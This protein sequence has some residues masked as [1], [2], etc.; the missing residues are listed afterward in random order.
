METQ[1]YGHNFKAV[2]A[3]KEYW[4]KKDPYYIYKMN[5]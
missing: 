4:D 2:A 5:D 3:Y 1:P